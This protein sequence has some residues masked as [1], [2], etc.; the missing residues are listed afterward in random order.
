MR[1]AIVE[2]VFLAFVTSLVAGI[3]ITA[4]SNILNRTSKPDQ[5]AALVDALY[6]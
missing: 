4:Q 2:I 5:T 3:L 6:R 1:K